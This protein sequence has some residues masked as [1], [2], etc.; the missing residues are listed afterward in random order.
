M[1]KFEKFIS[2]ALASLLAMNMIVPINSIAIS[3]PN[4]A[5]AAETI[6]K[7]SSAIMYHSYDAVLEMKNILG[8]QYDSFKE[9]LTEEILKCSEVIDV[10]KYNI[11]YSEDVKKIITSFISEEIVESFHFFEY[12]FSISPANLGGYLISIKPSY[13]Y[14]KEEYDNRLA[15]CESKAEELLDGIVTSENLDDTEKALLI[16]DRL[17]LN[18]SYDYALADQSNPNRADNA[19]TMYG[20]LVEGNAVCQGYSEAYSYLLEKVGIESNL[21]VSQALNH[22]WNIVF[23]DGLPYHVDVTW[24]DCRFESGSVLHVNFLLSTNKLRM[25]V[26]GNT[27]HNAYDY[28]SAPVST[29]YDNYYWQNSNTAF[30]LINDELYY[31]DNNV[32]GNYYNNPVAYGALKNAST[33]EALYEIEELWVASGGGLW[34]G[35]YSKLA[36]IDNNLI[37]S[38]SDKI[39]IY[40]T[41][42]NEC[43]EF[44]VPDLSQYDF[45]RIYGMELKGGYVVCDLFNSPNIGRDTVVSKAEIKY[46]TE[47]PI[48]EKTT[49]TNNI[50]PY[51]TI[52]FTLG[53]NI[54]VDGC[55]WGKDID[56]ANNEFYKAKSGALNVEV[57]SSGTYYVKVK[58]ICGNLSETFKIEFF[59]TILDAQGGSV[60]CDTIIT[61]NNFSFVLPAANKEGEIF[62]GWATMNSVDINDVEYYRDDTFYP[63]RV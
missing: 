59:E 57:D 9:Y 50:A 21:C 53:D 41:L 10:S 56:Y 52:T 31:M 42:S 32:T 7:S 54:G 16:H 22:A 1:K 11:K 8:D 43:N 24:D 37:F 17:A 20:A 12:S 28:N 47:A 49:V 5:V 39:Y 30:Q 14:S 19:F 55:Y 25:G 13:L 34:P 29:K 33:G 35:N 63:T 36:S 27:P 23:I 3:E 51:Q 38:T 60:V 18:C 58:D 46:D 48:I 2:M 6:T 4:G 61:A 26:N 45:Y 44:F 40:D 15:K 62:I